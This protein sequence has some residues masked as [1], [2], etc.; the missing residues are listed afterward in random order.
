MKKHAAF[1]IAILMP[2]AF[3]NAGAAS[4]IRVRFQPTEFSQTRTSFSGLLWAHAARVEA[5]STAPAVPC[6]TRRLFNPAM[7][8]PPLFFDSEW[9]VSLVG[10][11]MS[12]AA[13]I[14]P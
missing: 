14:T 10:A 5:A 6:N 9:A 7:T 2:V 4:S 8:F 11:P 3:S 13:Y 12:C 1:A